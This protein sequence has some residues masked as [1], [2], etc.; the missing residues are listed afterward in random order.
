[1]QNFSPSPGG[2]RPV[3]NLA[4]LTPIPALSY[5]Y[6]MP[7]NFS[8]AVAR[9]H[10]IAACD[11]EPLCDR[12]VL[13]LIRG[14]V[15]RLKAEGL[16]PVV[17]FDLDSTLYEVAPRTLQ[18][19]REGARAL[20]DRLPDRVVSRLALLE[21]AQVGYSMIDTL[22]AAGVALQSEEDLDHLAVLKEFWR[23]RFFSNAYLPYDRPY[24]GT[25]E[26]VQRLHDDGAHIVY[27]TGRDEAG[28]RGGTIANLVR[29]RFVYGA[30]RTLLLMKDHPDTDDL[31]HKVGAAQ[32]VRRLGTLAASL[33][34][35][36]RNLAGLWQAFPD[37]LHVFV[38]TICSTH[39]AP[40]C[41]GI[42]RVRQFGSPALSE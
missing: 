5:G 15:N 33:E 34:N 22:S 10:W 30:E 16:V 38:E 36:P 7:D 4:R 12:D 41:R 13:G 28:M 17:L 14:R 2:G 21:E 26:F 11:F 3:P 9:D 18:I 1:M 29:D 25:A 6:A 8:P 31:E 39:P 37:A 35:E 24:P 23:E 40:V 19:L 20:T 32:S 42:Y 27:L